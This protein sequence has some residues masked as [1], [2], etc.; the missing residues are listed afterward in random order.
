MPPQHHP[1]I[2][3]FTTWKAGKQAS[4]TA[5]LV[6]RPPYVVSYQIEYARQKAGM[7]RP[8]HARDTVFLRQQNVVAVPLAVRVPLRYDRRLSGVL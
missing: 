7:H 6:V 4:T 5:C 8:Q 2:P 3:A 1:V